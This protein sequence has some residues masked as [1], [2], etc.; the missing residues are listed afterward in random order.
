[1]EGKGISV[2]SVYTYSSWCLLSLSGDKG[3]TFHPDTAKG[4]IF[5]PPSQME[6]YALL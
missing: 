4:E 2:T 5:M 6:I 1:M 3:R